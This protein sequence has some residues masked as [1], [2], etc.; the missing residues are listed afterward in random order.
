MAVVN[1]KSSFI[2]NLDAEPRV[3]NTAGLYGGVTR[4]Y[5]IVHE[6]TAADS[7]TS[8]YRLLRL[9][10]NVRLLG[11]STISWDDMADTGSPTIDIG[12]AN[13]SGE[14]RI[15]DDP[16]AINDGLDAAAAAAKTTVIK[17][18]DN[19]GKQLWEFV[20]GQTTDPKGDLEIYVS[21]V[22][23]DVNLGGTLVAQFD[24]TF[25]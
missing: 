14:T 5:T 12:V 8:T 21:I 19:Y 15:T 24:I 2:T 16:D 17:T 18:I 11:S 25:D 3:L 22:D 9:P 23:A 6:I 20:S 7:D 4:S 13:V 1:E 10:S